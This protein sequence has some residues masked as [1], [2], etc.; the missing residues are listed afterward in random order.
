MPRNNQPKSAS[1]K[2]Y[3][4]SR[5]L[6]ESVPPK[7]NARQINALRKLGP[8]GSSETVEDGPDIVK[9]IT[10]FPYIIKSL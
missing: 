5:D 10:G 4:A 6:F 3:L 7:I 8:I 2:H 9:S 1:I